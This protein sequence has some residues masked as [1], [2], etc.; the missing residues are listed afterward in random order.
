MPSTGVLGDSRDEADERGQ[1]EDCHA[2]EIDAPPPSAP[3]KGAQ[4]DAERDSDAEAPVDDRE[5]ASSVVL[6]HER[7]GES[8]GAR[9]VETS[10]ERQDRARQQQRPISGG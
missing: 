8:D 2:E 1:R 5:S 7:P 3:D 6:R 10:C 9:T 4:R